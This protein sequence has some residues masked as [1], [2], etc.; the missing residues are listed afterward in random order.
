MPNHQD[1]LVIFLEVENQKLG[2]HDFDRY[3]ES[4]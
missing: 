3:R 1:N 2:V 4:I